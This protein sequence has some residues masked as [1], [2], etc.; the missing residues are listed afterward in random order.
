V[1]TPLLVKTVMAGKLKPK[2]LITHHFTLDDVMN[3]HDTFGTAG[4]ERA[5]KVIR[6]N[7]QAGTRAVLSFLSVAQSPRRDV[8]RSRMSATAAT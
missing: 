3:A 8:A 7:K 4:R 6:T 5:L 1:N 2:Q